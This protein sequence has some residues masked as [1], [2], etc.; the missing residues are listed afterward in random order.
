[1]K[2]I[3]V[4]IGVLLLA[5]NGFGWYTFKH[6]TLDT[7]YEWAN[8]STWNGTQPTNFVT[9]AFYCS[10]G[11]EASATRTSVNPGYSVDFTS[12]GLGQWAGQTSI[13]HVAENAYLGVHNGVFAMCS[14]ADYNNTG[15]KSYAELHME[16]ATLKVYNLEGVT[17]ARDLTFGG[18]NAG[19][20][21][22]V[23]LQQGSVITNGTS[24]KTTIAGAAEAVASIGVT[25]SAIYAP[26]G[27]IT[28]GSEKN[29]YSSHVSI[30]LHNGLF[31]GGSSAAP[32]SAMTVNGGDFALS[33]SGKSEFKVASFE[34]KLSLAGQKQSIEVSDGT[35]M[36]TNAT[37]GNG[38]MTFSSVAGSLK[39]L[40]SGGLIRSDAFTVTTTG[41][42]DFS[43]A[44]S[45]AAVFK[46]ASMT[47]YP[48][49]GT[50]QTIDLSD[51]SL[52]LGSG[53]MGFSGA[54]NAKFRQTGGTTKIGKLTLKTT[55]GTGGL[56]MAVSNAAVVKATSVT[57]TAEAGTKQAI[58]F[59]DSLLDL[60]GGAINLTSSGKLDFRQTGGK[61]LGGQ[62]TLTAN[63]SGEL[64][65][66]ISGE[67]ELQM[68]KFS[69]T[70][71][72]NAKL[73]VEVGGGLFAVT[74]ATSGSGETQRI[75][76]TGGGRILFRQTG[77]VVTAAGL[78]F[79]G[80]G[81]N[82]P[83]Y[84]LS[85]GALDLDWTLGCNYAGVRCATAAGTKAG[86]L[87]LVGGGAL[88][89]TPMFGAYGST[90][91]QPL[92]EYVIT[93]NGI[94]RAQ[95]TKAQDSASSW[96]QG[97]FKIRPQGG[98]QLVHTNVI[99][100]V[101]TRTA[102][103]TLSVA[104]FGTG[105]KLPN[106]ELWDAKL[107]ERGPSMLADL[108]VTL[109]PAAEFKSDTYCEEGRSSGYAVVPK[110]KAGWKKITV[111]LDLL[112]Q[113]DET[114]ET[115]KT[116][117]EQ[118]GFKASAAEGDYNVAVEIPGELLSVDSAD[119]K[120][121]FDFKDYPDSDSV[122]LDTPKVRALVRRCKVVKPAM[123]LMLLLF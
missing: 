61:V 16:G 34:S 93:T 113:G 100:L 107:A 119:D 67:T 105:T 99:N 108:P 118:A 58:D 39:L 82:E 97:F 13:V 94:P 47:M 110:V 69:P 122:R 43:M 41:A 95:F 78:Y 81:D 14:N 23:D 91:Y 46:A 112:P 10:T 103:R 24:G 73:T 29:Y 115:L 114:L 96:L 4:S 45:N 50:S 7:V 64:S 57:A 80:T 123:G 83:R 88:L 53:G 90:S 85:G 55:V 32:S 74:N 102:G 1:M 117:F 63:E 30:D 48:N 109:V 116:G 51:S 65:F 5:L 25:N 15:K 71:A 22:I 72:A 11:S 12:L 2:R 106:E 77:G 62:V 18:G 8:P 28:V 38:K 42:G 89:K 86:T 56:S 17:T 33:M 59:A 9:D 66:A 92:F 52:D 60:N 3:I 87:S 19:G 84:E 120:V 111:M 31:Y 26:S 44:V 36:I 68:T 35:L 76:L 49:A 54:G 20:I 104:N 75:K 37:S 40:Q 27:S 21:S 121:V 98:L 101:N 6:N 70:V 79:N